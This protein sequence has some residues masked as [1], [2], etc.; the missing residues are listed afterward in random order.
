MK[1]KRKIWNNHGKLRR[2]ITGAAAVI[3]GTGAKDVAA[4]LAGVKR[5]AAG[6][7]VEVGA[8]VFVAGAD[9]KETGPVVVV[10]NGV[11]VNGLAPK[12]NDDAPAVGRAVVVVAAG[13]EPNPN[14]DG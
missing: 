12:L 6:K 1:S 5:D 2:M 10:L 8:D 14:V 4:G 7:A 11:V 9:P 3:V 13:V